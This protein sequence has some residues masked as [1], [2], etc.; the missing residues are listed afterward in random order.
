MKQVDRAALYA[1][2]MQWGKKN[3]NR[4]FSDEDM[5]RDMSLL[6]LDSI[7]MV[8]F[9]EYLEAQTEAN[10][11]YEWLLGCETLTILVDELAVQ[12]TDQLATNSSTPEVAVAFS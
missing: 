11:D 5:V 10:I 2:V 4:Q 12:L 1:L 8:E 9:C 7:E 6:G 3:I